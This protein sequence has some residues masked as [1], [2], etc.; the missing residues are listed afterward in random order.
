MKPSAVT[1]EELLKSAKMSFLAIPHLC[2]AV[3]AKH[4]LHYRAFGSLFLGYLRR[5]ASI[6]F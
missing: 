1:L 4:P 3:T 6:G 5:V 2:G